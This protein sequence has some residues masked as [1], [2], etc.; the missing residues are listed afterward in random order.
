MMYKCCSCGHLFEEGEQAVWEERHGL[1]TPPYEKWSGCPICR[2][3]YEEVNQ[4]K[5]CGSWHTEDELTNGLCDECLNDIAME[6][7]YDIAKCYALSKKSGE[8]HQVEVDSFLADM[9]TPEQIN[10]VLYR[11]LVI[12]SAI[13]PVD[14]TTFIDADRDWF[15]EKIAEEVK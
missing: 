3:G 5:K 9:F 7:K 10:D 4:C 12:A 2:D 1:D 6:Y 8:T 14:C 11:E 15:N 13:K